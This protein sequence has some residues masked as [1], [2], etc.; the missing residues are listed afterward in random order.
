MHERS[1]HKSV[2]EQCGVDCAQRKASGVF[3]CKL[4]AI[5]LRWKRP[6]EAVEPGLEVLRGGHVI[7][8]TGRGLRGGG[9]AVR[10]AVL[11]VRLLGVLVVANHAGSLCLQCD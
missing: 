5:Y 6:L 7:V 3:K 4:P 9:G 8:D 2:C 1:E 11:A 10:A